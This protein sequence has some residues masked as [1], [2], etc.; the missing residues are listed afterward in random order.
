[1]DPEPSHLTSWHGKILL[2]ILAT[3]TWNGSSLSIFAILPRPITTFRPQVFPISPPA[4][5]LFFFSRGDANYDNGFAAGFPTSLD[6]L[7]PTDGVVSPALLRRTSSVPSEQQNN[8]LSWHALE[9]LMMTGQSMLLPHT[10]FHTLSE[11]DIAINIVCRGWDYVESLPLLDTQWMVIKELDQGLLGWLPRPSRLAALL[12][13][14][15][16]MG[17]SLSC[18]PSSRSVDFG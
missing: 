3:T 12:F 2:E 5:E 10:D 4:E 9:V 14:R 6:Q 13:T 17:V 16:V 7:T 15:M 1:M 18:L 8:L 11:E